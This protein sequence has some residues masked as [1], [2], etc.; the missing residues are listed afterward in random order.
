MSGHVEVIFGS[1]DAL[2][3][4]ELPVTFKLP[5]DESN[6]RRFGPLTW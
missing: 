6:G 5:F 3:E 2:S 4:K 1:F